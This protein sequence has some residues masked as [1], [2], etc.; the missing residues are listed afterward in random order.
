MYPI[1]VMVSGLGTSV[2]SYSLMI[3]N[4]LLWLCVDCIIKGFCAFSFTYAMIFITL[5][6]FIRGIELY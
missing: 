4:D 5:Y 2:K 1:Y 6:A 3:I